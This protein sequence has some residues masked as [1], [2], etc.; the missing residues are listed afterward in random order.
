MPEAAARRVGLMC[1]GTGGQ[2]TG[3]PLGISGCRRTVLSSSSKAEDTTAKIVQTVPLP[4]CL[5]MSV[6]SDVS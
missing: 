4:S 5:P 3:A 6:I 1:V 2:G